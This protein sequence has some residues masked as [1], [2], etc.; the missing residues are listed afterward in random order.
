MNSWM[1]CTVKQ[2][3]EKYSTLEFNYCKIND[4]E[5]CRIRKQTIHKYELYLNSIQNSNLKE[6]ETNI[7]QYLEVL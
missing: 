6:F 4:L 1:T 5:I 2:K 7:C 3:W